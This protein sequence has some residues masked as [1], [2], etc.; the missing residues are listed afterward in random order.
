[1]NYWK[2][3]VIAFTVGVAIA[4]VAN[5]PEWGTFT[6]FMTSVV[7]FMHGYVIGQDDAK[8]EKENVP[9]VRRNR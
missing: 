3:L 8:E 9:V 4:I 6:V 5:Y 2:F 1:M 7:Q